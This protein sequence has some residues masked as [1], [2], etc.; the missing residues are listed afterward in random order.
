MH[1]PK[2]GNICMF[3]TSLHYKC[4]ELVAMGVCVTNKEY[5]HTILHGIPKELA[6]FASQLLLST[7]L[8]H[9]IMVINT[10]TLINHICEEVDRL[11]NCCM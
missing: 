4:E 3:L 11:K 8:V 7:K 2:A 9:N 6:K 10:D 1:C 5:Q